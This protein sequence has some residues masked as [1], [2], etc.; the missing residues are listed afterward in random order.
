MIKTIY[1]HLNPFNFPFSSE[2]DKSKFTFAEIPDYATHSFD[3]I[4]KYTNNDPIIIDNTE[5]FTEEISA[6]FEKCKKGFPNNYKDPFWLLT[7]LRL[8]VVYLYVK[9]QSINTF[10]HLEYDNLIYQ[11]YSCLSKLEPKV[12]FTRV[13]PQCS[14]AGFMY[15]N[16]FTHFEKFINKLVRIIEKG[17]H[18]IRH[19][20][21]YDH[22]S[23]MIMIDLIYQHT[24][25]IMEYLPLL[26]TDQLAKEIGYV[27]DGASYGQYIG[28][29]NNGHGP[30]WYGLHHYVG[31]ALHNKIINVKYTDKPYVTMQNI[32]LPIFNLHVHSK[33]L[34]KYV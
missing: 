28:G 17:E 1:V 19:F 12:Y 29:T 23:E 27:F 33:N 18:H 25:N 16:S 32:T 8:Y 7:L 24:S 6:F 9:K 3:S 20:T 30:G 22:L 26:P 13:G 31:Q 4:K 5:T 2:L 34:G 15:C 11:N 14:S 10:V 21:Q